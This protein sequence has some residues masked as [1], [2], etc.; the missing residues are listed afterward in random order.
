MWVF[1]IFFSPSSR[2]FLAVSNDGRLTRRKD[3]GELK[4]EGI[5]KPSRLSEVSGNAAFQ[6]LSTVAPSTPHP[7]N[8]FAN[9]SRSARSLLRRYRHDRHSR[10]LP[11]PNYDSTGAPPPVL[12]P[13]SESRN[14]SCSETPAAVGM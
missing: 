1:L 11:T 4:V 8:K 6:L 12:S 7:S 10:S 2:P 5:G 13:L 3:N 9:V 14:R